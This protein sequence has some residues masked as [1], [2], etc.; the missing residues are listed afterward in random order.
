MDSI[1]IDNNQIRAYNHYSDAIYDW[2]WR[3]NGVI[4]SLDEIDDDL[5]QVSACGRTVWVHAK[6]G[7]TVGRF[8]KEF[9]MD[10]HR[11]VTEQM[12]GKSQCLNCTHT[13]P[14]R[15]DW[16]EFCRLISL[17]YGISVQHTLINI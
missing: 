6:D 12:Q 1:Y 2:L 3:K 17:H 13:K 9:G 14:T 11:T 5:I 16:V 8:S 15:E 7:S 4:M 10:V